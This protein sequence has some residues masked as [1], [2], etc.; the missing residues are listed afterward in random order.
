MLT[1]EPIAAIAVVDVTETATAPSTAQQ[2]DIFAPAVMTPPAP[3]E[4]VNLPAAASVTTAA[5]TS[6]LDNMLAELLAPSTDAANLQMVETA[7]TPA[8]VKTVLATATKPRAQRVP[9][10]APVAIEEPLLQVET[11]TKSVAE[12]ASTTAAPSTP[13]VRT[14]TQ[15]HTQNNSVE[16]VPLQQVETKH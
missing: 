6:N 3:V 12:L 1:V 9:A 8:T 10:S 13:R 4:V 15:Q 7:A 2:M 14:A 5:S 11:S 16:E